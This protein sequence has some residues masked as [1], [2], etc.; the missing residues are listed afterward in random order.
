M[1]I[2]K[3]PSLDPSIRRLAIQ[4]EDHPVDYLLFEGIIPE[5]NYGAG[6]VIVWDFGEYSIEK[7]IPSKLPQREYVG[8]FYELEDI[9]EILKKDRKIT[10]TL[11]GQKLIGKF[12]LVKI[13]PENHWLL[14][15]QNDEFAHRSLHDAGN[16]QNDITESNPASIL[17][18]RT[19]KDIL[20]YKNE[21]S[22]EKYNK[23]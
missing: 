20:K 9:S 1:G 7:K 10:F 16:S 14:I 13:N 21:K 19:N 15:K 6:T 8:E 22:S 12:S 4:T 18:G 2:P 3:G 5:G 23:Y 17:T 11:Y